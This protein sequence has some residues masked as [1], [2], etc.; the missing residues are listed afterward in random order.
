MF[1]SSPSGTGSAAAEISAPTKVQMSAVAYAGHQDPRIQALDLPQKAI[2][3]EGIPTVDHCRT[4]E[5]GE[6]DLAG[7]PPL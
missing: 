7:P 1:S 6:K 5:R 2:G 3:C 4:E